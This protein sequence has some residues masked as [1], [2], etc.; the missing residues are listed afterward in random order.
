[1]TLLKFNLIVSTFKYAEEDAQEELMNLLEG[2]GDQQPE[3]QITDINGI[4][5]AY[6]TIELFQLVY[7]LRE[8]VRKEPWQVRYVMR[9]L[10]IESVIRTNLEDIGN[11]AKKLTQKI[12]VHD[13]FRITVERRHTLMRSADIISTV[14]KEINNTVNLK[15]P[16][17]IVL[18]EI[19]GSLTGVSILKPTQIFSSMIEKRRSSQE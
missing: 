15:N 19:I 13:T 10:P 3:S 11:A 18:I 8:L 2:F 17:W 4:L 7:S 1:M 16:D 9:L 12:S 14:G 5:V 6:T